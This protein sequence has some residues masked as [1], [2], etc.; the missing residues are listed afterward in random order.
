MPRILRGE[1]G[2]TSVITNAATQRLATSLCEA[3]SDFVDRPAAFTIAA[4]SEPD[5]DATDLAEALI[6]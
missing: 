4:G 3:Q 5:L 6:E 2:V 1:A